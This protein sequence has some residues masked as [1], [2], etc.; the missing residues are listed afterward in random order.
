LLAA[1]A[2][3]ASTSGV[4]TADN[5]AVTVFAVLGIAASSFVASTL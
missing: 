2:A 1:S 4:T 3:G 5:T